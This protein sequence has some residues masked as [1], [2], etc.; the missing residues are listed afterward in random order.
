MKILNIKNYKINYW[1][2]SGGYCFENK[3]LNLDGF[4]SDDMD[5]RIK[6]INSKFNFWMVSFPYSKQDKVED[7][8]EILIEKALNH[9]E[10]K[11]DV[12][13]HKQMS[14]KNRFIDKEEFLKEYNLFRLKDGIFC[15]NECF[16]RFNEFINKIIKQ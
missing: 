9:K 11:I 3:E 10:Y 7:V 4:L 6:M 12:E 15:E 14:I 5:A 2:G 1:Y 13:T 8:I 16:E